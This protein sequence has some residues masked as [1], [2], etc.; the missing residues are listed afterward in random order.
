[1]SDT[2]ELV[3]EQRDFL[4][5]IAVQQCVSRARKPLGQKECE[6]CG[7]PITR[8]RQQLGATLCIECQ[9]DKESLQERGLLPR[10]S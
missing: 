5:E 4:N 10:G 3:Q 1:M 7:E 2:M 8:L 6:E 9:S